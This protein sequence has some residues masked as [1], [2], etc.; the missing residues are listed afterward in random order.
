MSIVVVF[1]SRLRPEYADEYGDVAQEMAELA[2]AQPGIVA[3]KTFA[4]A[5]GERVTV[6]EFADEAAVCAWRE[7]ERHKDAQAAGRDR[8]YSEYRVQVCGVLRDY[9]FTTPSK[10]EPPKSVAIP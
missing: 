9:G 3:F 10:P 5:D 2:R 6:A 8:F 7:H 1:R 4:A